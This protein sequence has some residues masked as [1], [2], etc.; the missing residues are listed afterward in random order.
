MPNANVELDFVNF[1][2]AINASPAVKS[3][4]IEVL[5][6]Y[7]FIIHHVHKFGSECLVSTD[8][9]SQSYDDLLWFWLGRS[10]V[11]GLSVSLWGIRALRAPAL[12][13]PLRDGCVPQTPSRRVGWLEVRI[14]VLAYLT[15]STLAPS[16]PQFW[17]KQ[18]SHS[19]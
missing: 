14:Q 17:G 11:S 12:K 13:L 4:C 19:T 6:D 3:G 2:I 15:I 5:P 9:S 8:Y 7:G 10:R 16:A 18:E 1:S